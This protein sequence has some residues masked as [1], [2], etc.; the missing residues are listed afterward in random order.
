M[1]IKGYAWD[2]HLWRKKK[3]GFDRGKNEIAMQS[4]WRLLLTLRGVLRTG[5]TSEL[6]AV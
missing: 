2:Q 1:S 6:L 5:G 4:L 3:T